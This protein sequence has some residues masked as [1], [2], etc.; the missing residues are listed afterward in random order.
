MRYI[1]LVATFLNFI[2]CSDNFLLKNNTLDASIYEFNIGGFEIT[3][4]QNYNKIDVDSKGTT[5]LP[6]YPELPTYSFN[7]SVKSDREYNVEYN[8]D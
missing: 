8:S 2:I 6:G 7:Y 5:R 1:L 4:D 3:E